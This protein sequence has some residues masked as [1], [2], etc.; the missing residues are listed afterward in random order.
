MPTISIN[1][2][3]MYYYERGQGFPLVFGHSFLWDG[4]MWEPTIEALSANYRCIV[5]DLWA[6][7]RSDLPD[8]SPYPIEKIAEDMMSFLQALKL[9]RFVIIG[10]SAG[11]MWGTHVALNHPENVAGLVLM[12]TYVG[13]ES[14]E[15]RTQYSQIMAAVEQAGLISPLLIE[16]LMPLFFSPLALETKPEFVKTWKQNLLSLNAEQASAMFAVG[17]EIVNRNSLL[18]RLNS[19]TCPCLIMVGENDHFRPPHESAEMANHLKNAK[20][21]IIPHAR[22]I[23]NVDQPEVV[24]GILKQF[25]G[26][27]IKS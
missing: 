8:Y 9:Q 10:L 3:Q 7:G 4:T 22:H 5:P 17:N 12:D 15:S 13:S 20:L 6:H 27:V 1:K 18:N 2:K 16:Q 14:K 24:N 23:S 25:L 26:E 11:G 21:E 19:I